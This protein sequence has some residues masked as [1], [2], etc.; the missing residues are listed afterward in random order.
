M[1]ITLP[2][3]KII[4]IIIIISIIWL[5]H[6]YLKRCVQL[7]VFYRDSTTQEVGHYNHDDYEQ[8]QGC[9]MH[10]NTMQLHI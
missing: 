9:G 3:Y 7:E 1:I 6:Q 5:N 8:Q 2:V 10:A 4:R